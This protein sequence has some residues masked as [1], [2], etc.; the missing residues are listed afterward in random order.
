MKILALT[1][2][3]LLLLPPVAISDDEENNTAKEEKKVDKAEEKRLIREAEK[4]YN[5]GNFDEAL[6]SYQEAMK[7]NPD[8]LV[9]QYNMV[10]AAAKSN[11]LKKI[12]NIIEEPEQFRSDNPELTGKALYNLATALLEEAVKADKQNQ[13]AQKGQELD[14]AVKYMR[15]SLLMQQD[16]QEAKNNLEIANRLKEKLEQQQQKQ[17]QNNQD[18]NKEKNKNKQDDQ[19]KDKQQNQDQNEEKKKDQQQQDKQQNQQQQEDKQEKSDQQKKQEPQERKISENMAK[20]L[21]KA[22]KDAEKK[23]LKAMRQKINSKKR[24]KSKNGRDW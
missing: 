7:V 14:A 18:Q 21:L 8:N 22:A 23:A 11:F 19:N 13:L 17:N 16:L 24:K 10:T 9:N 1:L 4:F 6:R 2:S 15:Q 12:M 20:N 5:Q 3:L